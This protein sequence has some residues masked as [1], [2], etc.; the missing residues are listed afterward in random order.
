M[1]H[2]TYLKFPHIVKSDFYIYID[3]S[4]IHSGNCGKSTA[5]AQN[6]ILTLIV[7]GFFYMFWFKEH[8]PSIFVISELI[9]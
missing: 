3:V 9:T 1:Y 8:P 4:E 7:L 2:N 5:Y 6:F